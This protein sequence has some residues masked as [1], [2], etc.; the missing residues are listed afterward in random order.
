MIRNL[1]FGAISIAA[2]A[3]DAPA[4]AQSLF[5][6]P[7]VG[8]NI[9]G[10]WGDTSARTNITAGSG[11]VR[12]PPQDIAAINAA[13]VSDDESDGEFTGGVQG[14]YNWTSGNLMF[15]VETDVSFL[16]LGV[17]DQKT[18]RSPL[19]PVDY[20]LT[21]DIETD[22]LWTVRPRI[23]YV[24]DQWM[25]FASAGFAMSEVDY[26]VNFTDTRSPPNAAQGSFSD[27]RT[28]WAGSIGA[29]YAV[30]EQWSFTGEWLYIDLGEIDGTIATQN[31][32]VSLESDGDIQASLLRFGANFRF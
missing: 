7:Y 14:G 20:S 29:A 12:I 18:V 21:Q 32:F 4:M 17:T 13:V 9:G 8:A 6:G 10:S 1:M 25:V 11:A 19:A 23:G 22:W 30:N 5:D 3:A 24:S 31:G 15:G 26:K 28:G 2:F 27:T 16:D